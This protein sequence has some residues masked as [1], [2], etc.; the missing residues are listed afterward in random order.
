MLSPWGRVVAISALLVVG[1]ALALAVGALAS[2]HRREVSYPVTG[3]LN[4]L[5]FDLAKKL[6]VAKPTEE[7]IMI[8]AD[9][10]VRYEQF[11]NVLNAL[12][13]QGRAAHGALSRGGPRQ[14]VNGPATRRRRP[15]AGRG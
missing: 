14:S 15:P 9:G 6:N 1:G 4:G 8:R 3:T 7:V 11:M 10:D 2:D 5:A 13:E 12:Q